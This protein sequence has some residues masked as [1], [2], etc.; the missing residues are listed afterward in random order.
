MITEITKLV[1]E[2]HKVKSDKEKFS[3]FHGGNIKKNVYPYS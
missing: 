2:K 3:D 1:L